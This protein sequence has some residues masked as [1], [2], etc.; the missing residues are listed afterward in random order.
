[1]PFGFCVKSAQ[2]EANLSALQEHCEG[3]HS[4]SA[5]SQLAMNE[6]L[7]CS[8]AV[9]NIGRELAREGAG[10]NHEHQV[11]DILSNQRRIL[12]AHI[13]FLTNIVKGLV[14]TESCIHSWAED[15]QRPALLR[16]ASFSAEDSV[17][18]AALKV[19]HNRA[20]L[21][22]I[23]KDHRRIIQEG[24]ETVSNL[25]TI[26]ATWQAKHPRVRQSR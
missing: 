13:D 11:G 15:F 24:R 25:E 17:K 10:I 8:A 1:M 3:S 2:R 19:G 9:S 12:D 22:N 18:L 4:D 21:K 6:A 20:V 16:E 23:A 5:L 26:L 7:A 14:E